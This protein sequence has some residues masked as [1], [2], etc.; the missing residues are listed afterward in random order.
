MKQPR[1][2]KERTILKE[3]AIEWPALAPSTQ[4]H[5]TPLV[6]CVLVSSATV[7]I[8]RV[9]PNFPVLSHI[10]PYSMISSYSVVTSS[11]KYS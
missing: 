5:Y 3:T 10:D 2:H 7:H 4:L 1:K 6:L 9:L 8:Y 11:E